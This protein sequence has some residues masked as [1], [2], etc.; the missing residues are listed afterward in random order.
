MA[1]IRVV[2]SLFR[3]SF[4]VQS[5]PWSMMATSTPLPE[6]PYFAMAASTL[7]S[8]R[9]LSSAESEKAKNNKMLARNLAAI[10]ALFSILLLAGAYRALDVEYSGQ[11]RRG[12]SL[13]RFLLNNRHF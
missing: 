9:T 6:T 7:V 2:P 3:R 4:W 5:T 11:T 1:A 13:E 12:S 8:T 10:T